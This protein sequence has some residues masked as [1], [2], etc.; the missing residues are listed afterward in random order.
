MT[1]QL[2]HQPVFNLLK[3]WDR[4]EHG[5][6]HDEGGGDL[7]PLNF[8]IWGLL[9]GHF[10]IL[11]LLVTFG[12]FLCRATHLNKMLNKVLVLHVT[13]TYISTD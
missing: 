8:K 10:K 4:F 13:C 7:C 3:K 5:C 2:L 9:G 11:S 12:L 1:L 6:L